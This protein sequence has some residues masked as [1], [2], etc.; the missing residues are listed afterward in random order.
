MGGSGKVS[1]SQGLRLLR[2][3]IEL[4]KASFNMV[5]IKDIQKIHPTAEV[6]RL[7]NNQLFLVKYPGLTLALSYKLLVGFKA[8]GR[9]HLSTEKVSKQTAKHQ[10]YLRE[11]FFVSKWYPRR[12]DLQMAFKEILQNS[13]Q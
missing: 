3:V 5:T 10:H 4:T 12:V 9:W 13:V 2:W 11:L 8:Y 1:I 6:E 7:K